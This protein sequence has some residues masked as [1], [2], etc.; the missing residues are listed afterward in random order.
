MKRT[1]PATFSISYGD[2]V[3]SHARRRC[4]TARLGLT[5]ITHKG[6]PHL[7]RVAMQLILP[8]VRRHELFGAYYGQKATVQKM[9]G[10]KAMTAVA[11]KFLKMIWG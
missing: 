10:P 1:A 4:S 9:P 7:R 6:R 11:R 2:A 5:K 8:L 3:A